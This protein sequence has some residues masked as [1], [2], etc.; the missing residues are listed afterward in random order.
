MKRYNYP[1]R[2]FILRY[3]DL[4]FD[5]DGYTKKLA[6]FLGLPH[7]D[8][9]K[10]FVARHTKKAATKKTRVRVDNG[11]GALENETLSS[12]DTEQV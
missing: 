10:K 11:S 3:E 1:G 8:A 6:A 7:L 5:P 9:I 4:C 2:A 12:Y